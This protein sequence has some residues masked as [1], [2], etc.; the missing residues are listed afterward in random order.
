MGR[1]KGSV[2]PDC[3]KSGPDPEDHKLFYDCQR[4]RAQAWYR[5]EQWQISE[6]DYIDL[7]R[8]NDRHL[9]K[10]RRSGDLCLVRRDITK[11]WSLENVEIVER[12]RHFRKLV[13]KE[14]LDV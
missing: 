4:A 3:W 12:H 10:G 1:P 11:A 7:W 13:G 6:N 14:T 2:S 9:R 5:G 8:T